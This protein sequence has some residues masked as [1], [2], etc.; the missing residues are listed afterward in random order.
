MRRR[1]FLKVGSASAI[2]TLALGGGL[3]GI[4]EMGSLA[5][6][7][8]LRLMSPL[9]LGYWDGSA[10]SKVVAAN[11]ILQGDRSFVQSG[12]RLRFHGI[13]STSGSGAFAD[14][15]SLTLDV[16]YRPYTDVR[17]LAWMLDNSG[18]QKV[19]SSLSAVVPIASTNALSLIVGLRTP[20]A[21]LQQVPV[22][23][24]TKSGLFTPKLLDGFHFIAM[25]GSSNAGVNWSNYQAVAEGS[26]AAL[27]ASSG[28]RSRSSSSASDLTYVAL[29]IAHAS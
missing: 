21:A 5:K 10:T 16:D 15:V 13:R 27:V 17:F 23:F 29:E 18:Y 22:T 20:G 9:S 24:S 3:G 4:P 8:G 12:V 11:S 1:E 14:I 25:S 7:A 28:G 2:A 19:S 26:G 6:A